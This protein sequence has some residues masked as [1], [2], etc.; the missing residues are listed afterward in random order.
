MH[1]TRWTVK[2]SELGVL[3]LISDVCCGVRRKNCDICAC[4]PKP[5]P[6]PKPSK[7][8]ILKARNRETVKSHS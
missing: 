2:D 6:K 1:L 4:K 8:N 5:K 7:M 3:S